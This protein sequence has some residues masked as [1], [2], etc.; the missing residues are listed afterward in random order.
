[1]TPNDTVDVAIRRGLPVESDALAELLWRVRRQSLGA[2]P[3]GV[4]PVEEMRGWMA[5]AVFGSLE[6]WVAE[7]AGQPVGLMILKRPDWLE[8]LYIDADFAGQGVGSRFVELAKRE[9]GAGL[10]LWTFQSNEGARRFYERHGFV[11]AQFTDGDNEEGSPDV[12]YVFR[13]E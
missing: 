13:P 3:P 7:A 4:H 6:V 5:S 8:H 9:L 12:R 2:I 10:Q 11:A 1:M